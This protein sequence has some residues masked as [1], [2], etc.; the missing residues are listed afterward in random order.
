MDEIITNEKLE[1]LLEEFLKKYPMG[2]TRDLAR[3]CYEKGFK[4]GEIDAYFV[5]SKNV[6]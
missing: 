4:D 5:M 1:N 2:D 3:F 6:R